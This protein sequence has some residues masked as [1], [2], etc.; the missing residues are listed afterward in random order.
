MARVRGAF[1]LI[2]AVALILF[3]VTFINNA[4]KNIKEQTGKA[5][6]I[7]ESVL[8][9]TIEYPLRLEQITKN[10]ELGGRVD[11]TISFMNPTPAE[12]YYQLS[13]Y[14]IS[15]EGVLIMPSEGSWVIYNHDP[16]SKRKP[17]QISVWKIVMEDKEEIKQTKL[18]T[19]V[20]CCQDSDPEEFDVSCSA[21]ID[22]GVEFRK[23]FILNIG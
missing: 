11:L 10:I 4:F 19:M 5:V 8:T 9:P 12:K 3:G 6:E 13:V 23:D 7:T 21:D 14:D 15:A 18:L 22:N 17:E 1:L 16:T 20:V 2:L